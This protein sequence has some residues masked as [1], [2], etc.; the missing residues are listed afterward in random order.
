MKER[1]NLVV[2]PVFRSCFPITRGALIAGTA[3]VIHI[4]EMG[5]H[6]QEPKMEDP[7]LQ[8]KYIFP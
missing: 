1:I 2:S 6:F 8:R 7:G 3:S 4:L 5:S